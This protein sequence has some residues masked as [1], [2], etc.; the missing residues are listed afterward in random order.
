MK[1]AR[2]KRSIAGFPTI[3]KLRVTKYSGGK[4]GYR[5][6]VGD[7]PQKL[8]R[9]LSLL[10]FSYW[11]LSL[12]LFHPLLVA[13]ISS[14]LSIHLLLLVLVKCLLSDLLITAFVT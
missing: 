9:F 4:A 12:L 1:K 11:H 7:L 2:Y 10:S 6:G 14:L 8:S 13:G 5:V 3:V